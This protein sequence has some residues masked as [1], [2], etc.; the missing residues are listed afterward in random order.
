[1]SPTTPVAPHPLAHRPQLQSLLEQ[2]HAISLSQEKQ[3]DARHIHFPKSADDRLVFQEQL[4]ALDEDKARA[5]YCILRAMGA[6][7]V[8]EAGTSHGVSLLW[9]LAAVLDNVAAES[10]ASKT[11]S[12]LVIGTENE[13]VK[14]NHCLD[15]VTKGFG[16]I[17]SSLNL[18]Q[19]DILQTLP[20]ANLADRSIDVLLL[21]IWSELALP[22][23]KIVLPKLRVGGI[24]LCDNSVAS[25]E[26]Y[27]ELLTFLRD[28]KSGF[29]SSTLPFSGGF[30]LVVF[31]GGQP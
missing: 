17:P 20:A 27:H 19:G 30:E 3:L 24:V 18:L 28:G 26:R 15:H 6:T 13:P 22:T 11:H 2:L 29:F 12:P 1:M 4:V 10:A 9:I 14:A 5:M 25:A 8:V 16:E 7:R 23:L 31:V 21:D